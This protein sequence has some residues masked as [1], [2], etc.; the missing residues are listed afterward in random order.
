M[1]KFQFYFKVFLILAFVFCCQY[2]G[3]TGT[4]DYR[5]MW[6][7]D[8]ATSMVIGWNQVSGNNATVYYDVIDRGTNI[9]NYSF[10]KTVDRSINTKGMNNRFARLTNL[11][12]N[13]VYYF[14]VA[15]DNSTSQRFSFKTT[16][17][18][19]SERLSFI[20][21]GD[22]RNNRT[23]RRNANTLV[24]K[25]RPHA[26]FFTGD[27]TDNDTNT[28][29]QDW[30]EDWQLT[31]GTDGRMIPIVATRG[32]HESNDQVLID[33]FDLP[34][35][36]IYYRTVFGGGL[37]SLYT[38]NTEISMSGNQKTW[39]TSTLASDNSTFKMANYHK[40]VRPHTSGKAEGTTQYTHWVPLF[41]QYNMDLVVECDSHMAKST[42][43][44]R[45]SN[46]AGSQEGFI[47]DDQNGTVYVGEG[48]W[49]A[50]LR[51]A[52]DSKNWTRDLGTFNQFK[53]I[54]VDQN[55]IEVR[56]VKVDNA[57]NVGTVNDNNIFAPP[58][59]LDINSPANGST[60]VI[61]NNAVV[62][63]NNNNTI[64]L[65]AYT[66]SLAYRGYN[67]APTANSEAS[68]MAY[69]ETENAIFKVS[70][71]GFMLK[72]DLNGTILNT[73]TLSGFQDTEGIVYMGNNEF[74]IIEEG[75]ARVVFVTFNAA[76]PPTTINY[77]GSSSY[78]NVNLSGE[79]NDTNRWL[80]GVAYDRTNQTLYI[81][82]EFGQTKI[83]EYALNNQRSG[84]ITPSEFDRSNIN[85]NITKAMHVLDNG[86]LLVLTAN[87]NNNNVVDDTDIW[88]VDLCGNLISTIDVD[89]RPNFNGSTINMEGAEGMTVDNQGN[90][91]I[92]IDAVPSR[93]YKMGKGADPCANLGGDTDGDGVCNNNDNCP[94]IANPGQEDDD[95]DNIGNVCDNDT[96]MTVCQMITSGANDVEQSANGFMYS[97]SSDIELVFDDYNADGTNAQGNQ[98]IGLRFTSLG[99]P[100]GANIVSAYIQ[101]TSDNENNDLDV[102]PCTVSIAGHD[103]DNSPAYTT[104][105]NNVSNRTSTSASVSWN[106]PDWTYPN[107]K[108]TAQK[109]PE[110]KSIVQEIVNR[111]GFGTN[112]S[113]SFKISGTGRRNASSASNS[114]QPNTGPELCISY[115]MQT[116]TCAAPTSSSESNLTNN[117]VRLNWGPVT[118]ASSYRVEYKKNTDANWTVSTS[119]TTS[120]NRTIS[121]LSASTAYQWR[122]RSN[123]GNGQTSPWKDD[124]FSTPNPPCNIPSGLTTT[125]ITTTSARF[126]WNAAT[127][128]T[129]YRVDYKKTSETTWTL[130]A[131]G[132]S[133]LTVVSTGLTPNTAYQ[134]RVRSNCGGVT[135]NYTTISFTTGT[136]ACNIPSNLTS[137]TTDDS[138]TLSWNAA[139]GANTYRLEY[140]TTNVSGW[141]VATSGTTSTSFVLSNLLANRNYN[142]R[143][144]SNCTGATSN[145]A[146]GTFT[147]QTGTCAT[148][149]NLSSSVGP[150][151]A[152][153][154]WNSAAGANT[155]RV[156]YRTSNV[157][158]WTLATA[159][160]SDPFF[161]IN[162]L[163]TNRDYFW[164]VR[165]N[166]SGSN[167]NYASGSF[168]TNSSQCEASSIAFG[169]C[170][171][172]E[173]NLGIFTQAT[174]DDINWTRK[175][176]RTSSS[177]TGPNSAD[178][179][180]YY[181]YIEASSPNFPS[182][183]ARLR[184]SCIT[185]DQPNLSFKYH[186]Y[187][188]A[189]GTLQV[190]FI[191]NNTSIATP[192]FTMSGNQGNTWQSANIDLTALQ[193]QD[194]IL[195]IFGNTGSSYT[196]DIAIDN[197]CFGTATCTPP[198]ALNETNIT[199]NSA[200]VRWTGS[201]TATSYRIEYK[202]A[203]NATW[204]LAANGTSGSQLGLTNLIPG[205]TYD[206]RIRSN[207]GGNVS[208]WVINTFSIPSDNP[209]PP[210]GVDFGLCNSFESD[211]DGFTQA[212][213]D[214]LNWT[215]K[216]GSTSS[217]AT[218]PSSAYDGT[219]Y[220]YIESSSPNFGGKLGRLI[221]KCFDLDNSSK[222]ALS[223][224]YHMY[225]NT[226]GS[227]KVNI[228]NSNN[229]STEVF[230]VSGDQGNSWKEAIVDLSS[231]LNQDIKIEFVG[232]T[233]SSY[234]SDI[235]IDKICLSN[236]PACDPP[237]AINEISINSNSAT[238]R[239]TASSTATSYRVEYKRSNSGTWLVAAGGTSGTQVGLSGLTPNSAYNWRVRSTC[240]GNIGTWVTSNFTTLPDNP[241]C[242]SSSTLSGTCESFET[243]LGIFKQNTNDDINWTRKSGG[244]GSGGT[245]PSAANDG[246]FYM[247]I[248][249]S[250]PNYPS[251]F[252]RLSTD[253][254]TLDDS[255]NTT[256][257]FKYHML[258][259][260]MGSLRVN[261]ISGGQST[262]V[263]N[264]SGNQGSVW[265]DASVDLSSY[266]N[267][268]IIIEFEGRT[269]SSYTSDICIDKVCLSGGGGCTPNP[270]SINLPSFGSSEFFVNTSVP[271][272][273][274]V[275]GHDNG[276]VF[277]IDDNAQRII[278]YSPNGSIIGQSTL[279]GFQDTE[280]IA[281]MG[282]NEFAI[283][284]ETRSRVVYV[285]ISATNMPATI[286][287]PASNRY[288]TM[289]VGGMEGIAYDRSTTTLYVSK[290]STK[291]IYKIS[292]GALRSGTI[293]PSPIDVTG[294]TSP[295]V[296]GLEF[297]P[298]GNLLVLGS[299]AALT[300]GDKTLFEIDECGNQKSKKDL[301]SLPATSGGVNVSAGK[302]DGIAIGT[303]GC[304]YGTID[305]TPGKLYKLCTQGSGGGISDC[306]RNSGIET[307]CSYNESFDGGFGLWVNPTG[308]DLNW[309]RRT[310]STSSSN[311]GPSGPSNGSHYTYIE[312]SSNGVGYPNKVAYLE[313]PCFKITS[314]G[315]NISFDYHMYGANMGMLSLEYTTDDVNWIRLWS[316]NGDQ[317][318]I[319]KNQI[320]TFSQQ[321]NNRTV[322][323][324]FKAVTGSSYRSDFAVDNFQSGC[325]VTFS[326][327][328]TREQPEV[329]KAK[330]LQVFPNPVRDNLTIEYKSES[331]DNI[332]I[333]VINSMGQV[334]SRETYQKAE[335]SFQK[336]INVS[337]LAIG[338]YHVQI[339]D[340]NQMS[341]ARFVVTK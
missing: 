324:R 69:H 3:L 18:N 321:L 70:D 309:L 262:Q 126:N 86:N 62:C 266:L 337:D 76:S 131:G 310:N 41:D 132:T 64:N 60:I 27:F 63:N 305:L 273:S 26:V 195:E 84:T 1:I 289:N 259:A 232:I 94:N 336:Q 231:Y 83:Y 204:L 303:D 107:Q 175:T 25:L 287:Y 235:A 291:E 100:Q 267:Q 256:L 302:M 140:K 21:G 168:R 36:P 312:S 9:N 151:F 316:A 178:E 120:T 311:T 318:N 46:A 220:M 95:N 75:R 202:V 137:T 12:P 199:S 44:I 37:I 169:S 158:N 181:L 58:T 187:G 153:V 110:L 163:L 139:S 54:F 281:Y 166:C 208:A 322:R 268:D 65:P 326:Q 219:S 133:S 338:I 249:A 49:G 50:P 198:T 43:P 248:E 210:V 304:I 307:T 313:S 172:F 14:V 173:T 264:V 216:S 301:N 184:S 330:E 252:A 241:T 22:S 332:D 190:K 101:F 179:G 30:F 52:N 255:N 124:S 261:I 197:I 243:G 214:D 284:E 185:I 176:G 73:T 150:D 82:Q 134:W 244:T 247:Y 271:Q 279:S 55:K 11:Q 87:Q 182:K 127:G 251:K 159:G 206:W 115:D 270:N 31:I 286:S 183:N 295:L 240:G 53:W 143:V 226:M 328:Q 148:P 285:T 57:D 15:D 155:Y 2:S 89:I 47:R 106:I 283:A 16:P 272:M 13:T 34:A 263:F 167:S 317:G 296:H 123:C 130:R 258:G 171:G 40:P 104:A 28:Q 74:A 300:S 136:P 102:N 230:S 177:N 144:R 96:P 145:F 68:G 85:A 233:G 229:Q 42:W 341:S 81:A 308:D 66:E 128:A 108:T 293:N 201:S 225:G 253:C 203:S 117:S 35:Q 340:G 238:V 275:T 6:R 333:Q 7:Q 192:L 112:S 118:G 23:P 71:R 282:N 180:S 8:P 329:K 4:D 218:G 246:S 39:L 99:I 257:E 90:I 141:T 335:I 306:S 239:W 215:R 154:L 211:L 138:A 97:S 174:D 196:S 147:T 80:E 161:S 24:K 319:W 111:Q 294:I 290:Q 20:A 188:A 77:P 292:I 260:A 227:L 222:T 339:K 33:L 152:V 320:L 331:S 209:C 116:V 221:S 269:G 217:S 79:S 170:E 29:W 315:L 114:G 327:V 98:I 129:S 51:T 236:A 224:R 160:T 142:W 164:R 298:N 299:N 135:S 280:A 146:S 250:S 122:V 205:S 297:L 119:A 5:I 48:C 265:K 334:M 56:S 223:F 45:A 38:L 92:A 207:C 194:G 186:M 314:A 61:N 103:S 234:R 278:Q 121:N 109:T 32:N 17:N 274:G 228:I 237:T 93:F 105:T 191:N 277:V 91:Y 156:E 193:G 59:N 245:G 149:E 276:N 189:M 67:S 212:T 113:M 325:N 125:D 323:L 242:V 10:S 288:M 88:E 254:I 165:S 213:N 19:S 157:S 162:N 72:V 200:T 78:I